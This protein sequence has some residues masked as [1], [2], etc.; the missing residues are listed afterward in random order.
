[1]CFQ[2]IVVTV[3]EKHEVVHLRLQILNQRLTDK[4][5]GS[6]VSSWQEIVSVL[7]IVHV[8]GWILNKYKISVFFH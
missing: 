8:P 7:W 5:G 3:S 2:N 6:Y 4:E 1:M